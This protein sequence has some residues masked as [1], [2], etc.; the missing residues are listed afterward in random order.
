MFARYDYLGAYP[1]VHYSLDV[2]DANLRKYT[3]TIERKDDARITIPFQLLE[4]AQAVM[5]NF[6]WI[7]PENLFDKASKPKKE[8]K[9]DSQPYILEIDFLYENPTNDGK[10]GNTIHEDD[11]DID[12]EKTWYLALRLAKRR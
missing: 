8:N 5:D 10:K 12:F 2:R 1:N 7:S 3:R 9:D 6:A 4:I 11:D